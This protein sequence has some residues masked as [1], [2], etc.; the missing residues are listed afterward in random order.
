MAD[1]LNRRLHDDTINAPVPTGSAA[2]GH[3]LGIGDVIISRRD[4]PTLGVFDAADIHT[5]SD[6]VRN[7]QRATRRRQPQTSAYRRTA[8][9]RGARAPF[10]GDY[11]RQHITH[12]YAVT[13]HS[14]QGVNADTTAPC[15]ASTGRWSWLP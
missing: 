5:A 10:S 11:L 6:A 4:E 8:P 9:R 2:R 14:A 1:A 13:V 15:S 7:G 3:R 12:G